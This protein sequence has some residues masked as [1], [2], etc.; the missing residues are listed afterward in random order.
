[1]FINL[2]PHEI[3]EVATG[4]RIPSTTVARVDRCSTNVC[5]IDGVQI[6]RSDY[7]GTV[8]NLPE[9]VEGVTYIVSAL[10]L[11]AVPA[12]RTDVV[13]PGHAVRDKEKTVIGCKG[14]RCR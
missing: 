7:E 5:V 3:Y 6:F 4:L 2:T 10:T 1:M 14:F 11:N 13:V 9:P 8:E 12:D